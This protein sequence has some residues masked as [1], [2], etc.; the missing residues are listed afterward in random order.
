MKPKILVLIATFILASQDSKSQGDYRNLNQVHQVCTGSTVQPT[1]LEPVLGDLIITGKYAPAPYDIPGIDNSNNA[2]RIFLTDYFTSGLNFK[3]AYL[4]TG[5]DDISNIDDQFRYKVHEIKYDGT[6]YVICGNISNSP[7][8]LNQAFVLKTDGGGNFIWFYSYDIPYSE[9]LEFNSIEPITTGGVQHGYIACGYRVDT[10]KVKRAIVTRIDSM[11]I[12]N[13]QTLQL[14]ETAIGTKHPQ[15]EYKKVI[16]YD[17]KTFALVGYCGRLLDSCNRAS[18]RQVLFSMYDLPTDVVYGAYIST[19]PVSINDYLNDSGV[20]LVKKD[21]NL[22]LLSDYTN[23]KTIPCNA[24][25]DVIGNLIEINPAITTMVGSWQILKSV[26]FNTLANANTDL[27][28]DL[29]YDVNSG[30]V[31]VYGNHTLDKGY[32]IKVNM[33]T[34]S[35]ASSPKTIPNNSGSSIIDGKTIIYNSNGNVVG[36]TD[37]NLDRYSIFEMIHSSDSVCHSDSFDVSYLVDTLSLKILYHD[38]LNAVETY[39]EHTGYDITVDLDFICDTVESKHG[40][41]ESN[42]DFVTVTPNPSTFE[43][44]FSIWSTLDCNGRLVI[45][46]LTGRVVMIK[47]IQLVK[48]RNYILTDVSGLGNGVYFF[49]MQ[50]KEKTQSAKFRVAK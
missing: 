38:S 21:S 26:K 17:S 33:A 11:G 20:S 9:S 25:P 4:I 12:P 34:A 14:N 39:M 29:L 35:N 46:D 40:M 49:S 41:G 1:D 48:G 42:S 2:F 6:D 47:F 13:A 36:L 5:V 22:I 44:T 7:N 43:T 31:W 28:K 15:S 19:T 45:T 3:R 10:S 16:Q 50:T 37:L 23:L 8:S 30:S 18:Q 27:P 32:L 24:T